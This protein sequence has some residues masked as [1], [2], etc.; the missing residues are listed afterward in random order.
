MKTYGER[1]L[2]VK[3]VREI[4]SE[5]DDH[6]QVCIETCDE[7]GDVQDLYPMYMD[8]IEGIRLTDG[9]TVREVRFCQMPNK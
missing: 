3:E 1:L 8:V 2:T 5:L 7:N 4:L 9:T 6:D